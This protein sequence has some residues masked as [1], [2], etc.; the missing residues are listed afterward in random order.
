MLPTIKLH[1]KLLNPKLISGKL[2]NILY[3]L[4][5]MR[6]AI[7]LWMA[8]TNSMNKTDLQMASVNYPVPENEQGSSEPLA[9]KQNYKK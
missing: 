1:P 4:N 7:C 2:F 9:Y 6:K 8:A 3:E 5:N